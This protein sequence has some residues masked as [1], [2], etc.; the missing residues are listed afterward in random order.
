MFYLIHY[1]FRTNLPKEIMEFP[2][3]PFPK[4]LNSFVTHN[5]VQHYLEKY[6]AHYKLANH[7]KVRR[8]LIDSLYNQTIKY[9]FDFL[10]HFS[11]LYAIP[12]L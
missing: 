5:D 9:S 8:N 7:I 2:G 12:Q 3:F 10:S 4:E 11:I 1:F 6:A